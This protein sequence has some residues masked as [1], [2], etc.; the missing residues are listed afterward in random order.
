MNRILVHKKEM[1]LVC[2]DSVAPSTVIHVRVRTFVFEAT[3]HDNGCD[4]VQGHDGCET[5]VVN[6]VSFEPCTQ[7]GDAGAI[8][9]DMHVPQRGNGC[10][11]SAGYYPSTNEYTSETECLPNSCEEIL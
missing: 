11:C 10:V 2:H 6:G 4:G 8:C 1:P 3:R 9:F 7:Y 5:R